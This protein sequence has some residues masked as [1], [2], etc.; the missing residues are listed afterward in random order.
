ML[1]GWQ[2]GVQEGVPDKEAMAKTRAQGKEQRC[3]RAGRV[4][5]GPREPEQGHGTQMDNSPTHR[6]HTLHSPPLASMP[7]VHTFIICNHT[8]LQKKVPTHTEQAD[9]PLT[10]LHPCSHSH[11]VITKI[12]SC[13]SQGCVFVTPVDTHSHSTA[14][15][16]TLHPLPASR[17]HWAAACAH[18]TYPSPPHP[19]APS[20]LEPGLR[21]LHLKVV[22]RRVS[23]LLL[24][25]TGAATLLRSRGMRIPAS[26]APPT[27]RRLTPYQ[28]H[29]PDLRLLLGLPSLVFLPG[30]LGPILLV[31]SCYK[32]GPP[33]SAWGPPDL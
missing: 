9:S 8:H 28:H 3:L 30:F 5:S 7:R 18:R 6:S 33:L 31:T 20:I 26:G 23:G 15:P 32:E 19:S 12:H 1:G 25:S 29:L 24:L 27:C 4:G 17:T 11:S 14:W 2:E 16:F 10:P 13:P 21:N 22:L